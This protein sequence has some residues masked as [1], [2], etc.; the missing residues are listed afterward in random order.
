[1]SPSTLVCAYPWQGSWLLDTM[2]GSSLPNR[3]KPFQSEFLVCSHCPPT[4]PGS[5][6]LY[7]TP[8]ANPPSMLIDLSD[9][10]P[11]PLSMPLQNPNPQSED[12]FISSDDMEDD[13]HHSSAAGLK[14]AVL[15]EVNS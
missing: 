14:F 15:S 9:P 7:L 4:S 12:D 11:L 3:Y 1:M 8:H 13:E 2:T 10:A 6:C 5:C